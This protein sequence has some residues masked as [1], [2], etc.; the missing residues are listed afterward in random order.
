MIQLITFLGN[1]GQ[2]YAQTRHN[3][4]W[5]VAEQFSE[6]NNLQWKSKFKAEYAEQLFGDEKIVLLKPQ[7]FMNNSGESVVAC[8]QFF[9]LATNTILVVHDDIELDF[10]VVGLK[11][12]G[13]LAGHNGLRSIVNHLGTREFY[14]FRIGVSRPTHG[15]VS[16]YVLS[17][18]NADEMVVLPN[19]VTKATDWLA[20][21][22]LEL[23]EGVVQKIV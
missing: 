6:N 10:G 22:M 14:R 7:T 16:S 12:G 19:Y 21:N 5:M 23:P 9:K 3:I 11:K 20:N 13:G 18:F 2:Q 8:A 15:N 4:A 1:P 17:K